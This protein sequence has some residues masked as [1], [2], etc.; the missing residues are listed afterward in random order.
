MNLAAHSRGFHGLL[1]ALVLASCATPRALE[2]EEHIQLDPLMGDWEGH[3]VPRSGV[4]VPVL[5]QVIALGDS[6]YNAMLQEEFGK[7]NPGSLPLDFRFDGE[8]ILFP[9]VPAMTAHLTD[10]LI[11]GT[12]SGDEAVSF[13]LRR[14]VRL[15]PT[16]G[17][18]APPGATVLFDGRSLDEW[19]RVGEPAG[20]PGWKLVGGD[21]M[22]VVGGS[23]SIMTK[24]S[25]RDFHLH[26][27]F[28][29]P[30]MPT[31]RGQARGNSGVY[32]QGRYEVQVLDSYGLTG[33]DNE[34]GG[35]YK[36]S[37]PLLNMCAPPRPVA[38][39]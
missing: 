5:A 36:V 14:I 12:S 2:Q 17:A 20:A 18:K 9:G 39:L 29:T 37:K 8:S 10:N 11:V 32:L 31:A 27:E 3:R 30:F 7:P 25:F 28:R 23:G 4:V 21:A 1:L 35:I 22:E 15:S 19:T 33:E 38:D 13:R 26:L 16:L 6:T 34:C 24:K